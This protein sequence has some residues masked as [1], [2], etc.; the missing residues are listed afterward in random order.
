MAFPASRW[1]LVS[2]L[3]LVSSAGAQVFVVGEKTATADLKTDFTRTNVELPTDPLTERGRRGLIRNLE[4]EQGFARR[5]LP[6]G[7]ALM[8]QANGNI[9]PDPDEY[10]KLIYKKGEAA[11]PGDRVAITALTFK[12]DQ[13]IVD[14]NGGPYAKHRILSH[15]SFNDMPVA[16]P[17]EQATGTRIVLVFEGGVP[18][19]DGPQLKALLQPLIDFGF[20]N[21]EEAYADTLPAPIKES[22]AAHDVLVG[23]N[24]R[25]VLAAVGEPESKI[26]EHDANDPDGPRYEEWIYG[27]VPQTVR[28]VRFQGDLV[29]QVKVAEMGKPIEVHTANEMGGYLPDPPT[30]EVAL[31][32]PKPGDESEAAKHPAPSLRKPGE[33]VMLPNSSGKVQFPEDRK[34]ATPQAQPVPSTAPPANTG[35]TL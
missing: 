11:M 2:V 16:Q 9:L 15:I 35:P 14:L 20:K 10:R 22:V 8:L 5:A 29:T 1:A 4:S 32:D 26:R 27:H 34:P 12:R 6:L 17:L 23:M 7:S 19:I 33:P 30:R 18:E 28:F 31:G 25:M 13:I 24:R 21:S 3:L